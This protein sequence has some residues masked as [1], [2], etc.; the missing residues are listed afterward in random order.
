[1]ATKNR[2]TL[3]ANEIGDMMRDVELEQIKVV[4]SNH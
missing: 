4:A 2:R 3:S 1:M